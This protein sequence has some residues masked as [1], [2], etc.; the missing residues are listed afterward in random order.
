MP[1]EHIERVDE[2]Q[3][4]VSKSL[5]TFKMFKTQEE[6]QTFKDSEAKVW[7]DIKPSAKGGYFVAYCRAGELAALSVKEA[8]EY[9]KLN[10]E[11]TAGYILGKNWADCH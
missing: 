7:S 4:E 5:V 9:Y 8:G 6:A 10:V 2:S 11:L 3:L 1:Y